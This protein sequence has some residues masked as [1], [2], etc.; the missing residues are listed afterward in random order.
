MS[1]Q[2]NLLF[3][4]LCGFAALSVSTEECKKDL[5]EGT[6][7]FIKLPEKY[8]DKSKD[9]KW[10][11]VSSDAVIERK[12]NKI[13]K[14]NA[15]G[16]TMD[17]DG[18]LRFESVSLN[19]MG[20]YLYTVTSSDG[21]EVGKDEV[22][23]KVYAKAP[24]PVVKISCTAAGNATLTC[25]MGNSK[26]LTVSWYKEGN[27][28]QND[29]KSQVFLSSAQVLENKLY[30]CMASNP[31]SKETSDSITVS[32]K[33]PGLTKLF[34]FDFWLMVGILAGGAALLLLLICVLVICACRSCHQRTKRQQDEEELR[35][36]DLTPGHTSTNRSKQ[37]ARGQPA[38]PIPQEDPMPC[39]PSPETPPR[40]QNQPKAQIRA[41]PPPP[42]Q[43]D[44]EE[45]PP[46][47]PR[48]RNKQHR[49]KRNQEPYRPME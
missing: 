49:T 2:H 1:C 36:A 10:T 4:L 16:L 26:D 40:T 42:P 47:L 39:N 46:P 9:I 11:H 24:K 17:E 13:K 21:T 38:P 7:C 48:P 37:T 28:F 44:D 23:I 19:Y 3:L 20:K 15:E 34:G 8:N 35:L 22:E 6:S 31:V 41:R 29:K 27:Y 18:S 33:G 30:S 14:S 43:D 5:Q 45:D 25:D 12:N 32:C